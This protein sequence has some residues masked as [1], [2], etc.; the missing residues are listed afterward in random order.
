MAPLE[1]V[2]IRTHEESHRAKVVATAV[3][4]RLAGAKVVEVAVAARVAGA[5]VAAL[6]M[7]RCSTVVLIDA[8]T[9]TSL[10]HKT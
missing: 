2:G 7:D 8:R 1:R 9:A 3:A 4:A 5:K 10:K 6:S